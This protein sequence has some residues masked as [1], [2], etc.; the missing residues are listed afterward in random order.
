[1]VACT[2]D[3]NWRSY[4]ITAVV[5]FFAGVAVLIPVKLWQVVRRWRRRRQP[6]RVTAAT[7]TGLRWTL[8]RLRTCAEGMLAGNST[9]NKI[10]V[11]SSSSECFFSQKSSSLGL[12]Q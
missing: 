1:M 2:L 11:S 7:S 4:V 6:R 5:M 3:Y 10:Y 12:Q 9:C 8:A